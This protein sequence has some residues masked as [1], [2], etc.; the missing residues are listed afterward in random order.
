MKKKLLSFILAICLLIPCSL[1][2]TACGSNPSDEPHT[3]NWS[4]T[5]SKNASEHWLTCD[6]CDEKKDKANH[7]GDPCSIC[8]YEQS[9]T[10]SYGDYV[11]D[12]EHHWKQCS[13]CDATTSKVEH[14]FSNNICLEC[15]YEQGGQTVDTCS[16][17]CR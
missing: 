9:H 15:G 11:Y 5:W 6:G 2:L 12:S 13:S 10:C 1:A 3:H 4:T 16:P 8:G 14:S 7:N 17:C